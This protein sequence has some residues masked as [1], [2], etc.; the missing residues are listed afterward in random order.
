MRRPQTRSVI[1]WSLWLGLFFLLELP[2]VVD[3]DPGDTLSE[4][5]W[6]LIALPGGT[7]ALFTW[8]LAGIMIWLAQHWLGRGKWRG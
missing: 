6:Y 8:V 2:A 4:L 3:D 7:G 5:V 1:A